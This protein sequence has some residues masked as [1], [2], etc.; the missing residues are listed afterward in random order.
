VRAGSKVGAKHYKKL[1]A[2]PTTR[3]VRRC[4]DGDGVTSELPEAVNS[5]LEIVVTA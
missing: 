2:S 1:V 4:A 5:V 3:T